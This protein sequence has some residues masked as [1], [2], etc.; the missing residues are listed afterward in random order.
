M[1]KSNFILILIFFVLM[2]CRS[3]EKQAA[4]LSFSSV[5]G[6]K[7]GYAIEFYS[8]VNMD[9]IFS[10]AKGEDV[11]MR[12]LLCSLSDDRDFRVEH[13]MK[14]FF[15]GDLTLSKGESGKGYKYISEGDFFVNWN[16]N[17]HQRVIEAN[18]VLKLLSRQDTIE[19][20]V[21]MII[22]LSSPY[23][24]ESMNIPVNAIKKI[25]EQAAPLPTCCTTT[26]ELL[27]NKNIR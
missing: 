25:V 23:Y 13:N 9:S 24:S 22:Y 8:D 14:K 7:N 16:G 11:V 4:K 17:T 3:N 10:E 20:K 27:E 18:D 2:S 5:Y 21:V 26:G 19:C 15:R 12:S 6:T 1:K